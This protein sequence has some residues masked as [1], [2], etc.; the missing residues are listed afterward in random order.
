LTETAGFSLI[1]SDVAR[2]ELATREGSVGEGIY[3][4]EWNERTYTECLHRTEQLIFEGKRVVV[5]ATFREEKQ[6]RTFLNAAIR[7]GIQGVMLLCRAE[8]ETVRR[9]LE[10]RKGDASDADWSIYLH[11]AA[12][13]EKPGAFTQR[14]C[15][16]I[17]TEGSPEESPFR[18]L[19]ILRSLGLQD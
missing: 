4:P 2:K 15:H 16:V 13:W 9:R 8:P 11:L 14:F 10:Q 12:S 5:D 1:R 3:T 19:G 17:S 7:L 18:A 6:R